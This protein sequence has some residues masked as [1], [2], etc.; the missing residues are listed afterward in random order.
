M[1]PQSIKLLVSST[2]NFN[3]N[4]S[5]NVIIYTR[6]STQ[7]QVDDGN[8][9][10]YQYK[11]CEEYCKNI[12]KIKYFNEC[13]DIGSSYNNLSALTNLNKCL[14]KMNDNSIIL[15]SDVS[16]LGRN[17]EQVF[18]LTQLIKKNNSKII[19]VTENLCFNYSR[20][21]NK[22]FYHKVI[23]SETYCDMLSQKIHNSINF[24]RNNGGHIGPTP[25]GF[26][27]EKKNNISVLCKSEE[28]Q[29]IIKKI[30]E[31]FKVHKN[32]NYVCTE[33]LKKKIMKRKNYWTIRSIKNLLEAVYPEHSKIL[34]TD[35][36][37]EEEEKEKMEVVTVGIY[38]KLELGSFTKL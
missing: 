35:F 5:Q 21:M 37:K 9:L 14:R 3:N 33:L 19:S 13:A 16:R 36:E 20:I 28:E 17:V 18:K 29:K 1:D 27:T 7:K 12:L 4:K 25:Y 26:K 34:M 11:I 10:D 31:F 23:D 22:Q 8:G 2:T 32:Y 38:E 30:I 24:R 6:V 15:I